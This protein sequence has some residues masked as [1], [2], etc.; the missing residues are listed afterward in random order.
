VVPVPFTW[1]VNTKKGVLGGVI[2]VLL[3]NITS[4]DIL[5]TALLAVIGTVAS[6]LATLLMKKL[7]K[8]GDDKK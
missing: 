8:S 1:T 3:A 5:K 2:T 6:Y 4:S 7:V